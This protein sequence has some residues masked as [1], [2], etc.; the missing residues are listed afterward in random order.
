MVGTQKHAHD[1]A[2]HAV[3]DNLARGAQQ[4]HAAVEA[5]LRPLAIGKLGHPRA[6]A[7]TTGQQPL[8]DCGMLCLALE[9]GR[10]IGPV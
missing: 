9:I 6:T 5:L 1:M 2:V 8:Q 4:G 3:G 10:L 7:D